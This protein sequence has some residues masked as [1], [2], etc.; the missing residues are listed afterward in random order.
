MSSTSKL[1]G[2][3][4]DASRIAAEA[5]AAEVGELAFERMDTPWV[6]GERHRLSPG[7]T[8]RAWTTLLASETTRVLL[9]GILGRTLDARMTANVWR[10]GPG[11]AGRF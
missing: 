1:K 6:R 7:G 2:P 5:L 11:D 3:P 8:L 10:L 4:G 9:G